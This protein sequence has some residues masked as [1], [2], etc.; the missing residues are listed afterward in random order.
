MRT[1]GGDG[2]IA[3]SDR[4]LSTASSSRWGTLIGIAPPTA[5]SARIAS[6]CPGVERVTGP[7]AAAAAEDDEVGGGCD[8]RSGK[9]SEIYSE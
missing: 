6:W 7:A 3:V 1:V 4:R 8:R 5:D 2:G 9:Q